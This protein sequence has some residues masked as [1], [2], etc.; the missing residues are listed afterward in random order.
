MGLS[1]TDDITLGLSYDDVLLKP[2]YSTVDRLDAVDTT[3]QLTA[4]IPLP[5][6]I[7]S[8]PMDTV[9]E[10]EMAVAMAQK[11]GLGIIHRFNTIAEEARH[12]EH[13]KEAETYIIRNPV[14]LRPGSTVQDA[15][16]LMKDLSVSS[17]LIT[18]QHNR[19]YGIATTGDVNFY[20]SPTDPIEAVMTP[21]EE[22]VTAEPGI[23]IDEAK[24]R[25][26]E[27]RLRKLPLV[28][29][30]GILKGLITSASLERAEERDGDAAA[31]DEQGRLRVGAAIGVADDAVERA[32]A[33]VDAGADV[34]CI[35]V[36]HGHLQRMITT[37]KTVRNQFGDIPL[38]AGNVATA[39]GVEDLVAAGADTVKVGIGPGSVCTTR[40]VAGA[41]VPQFTAVYTCAQQAAEMD[42]HVIA[43]GGIRTSGDMAKALAAGASTVMV[44]SMLAGSE[45]S[46]GVEVVQDGERY[47]TY[48]GMA[49]MEAAEKRH[50][51]EDPQTP[52][53]YETEIVEG[54]DTTV[55]YKGSAEDI[56]RNMVRG[57]RSAVSY[58][59]A[60]TVAGMRE[61]AAFYRMTNAGFRESTPHRL[62][63]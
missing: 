18:D 52:F 28:N 56:L 15:K 3:T 22:L 61:N 36:A 24:T 9:T 32:E 51:R 10:G 5:L 60:E 11:G 43:D 39:E 4:D 20:D 29:D 49:S 53:E 38:I 13:V 35:D 2:Q 19:L 55:P 30:Q 33:L 34:L 16:E 50:K 46:P 40:L 17:V 26:H 31:K 6:P 23:G 27:E 59:G 58:C 42:A 44:G 63:T 48:H 41:G 7:L 54:V 47:K 21:R 45:E 37:I 1:V 62:D 57:L 25:L 14:T 8:A 12:V